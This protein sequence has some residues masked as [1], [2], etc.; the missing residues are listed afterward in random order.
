MPII[1]ASDSLEDFSSCQV[2]EEAVLGNPQPGK[3]QGSN[4]ELAL[5]HCTVARDLKLTLPS[6]MASY[7][8]AR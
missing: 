7:L 5:Y 3:E 8:L 4:R 2:P 1:D 6:S